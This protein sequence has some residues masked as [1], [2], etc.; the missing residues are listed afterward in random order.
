MF[1]TSI[2][3]FNSRLINKKLNDYA[4]SYSEYYKKAQIIGCDAHLPNELASAIFR[5]DNNKKIVIIE[6]KYSTFRN[7]RSSM[8]IKNLKNKSYIKL[9]KNLSLLLLGK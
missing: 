6:Q 8:I 2:E 3:V 9:F 7:I 5:W 4:L 1:T